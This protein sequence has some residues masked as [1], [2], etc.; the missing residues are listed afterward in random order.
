MVK[1]YCKNTECDNYHEKDC[2]CVADELRI[3]DNESGDFVCGTR[4]DLK[5][6]IDELLTGMDWELVTD[7]E[8]VDHINEKNNTWEF[9][10]EGTAKYKDREVQFTYAY[11]TGNQN[12]GG[13]HTLTN[14][15]KFTES[16][17]DEI[18]EWLDENYDYK[19][20]RG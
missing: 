13:G 10:V 19:N 7:Y 2:T 15:N 16:E 5:E 1:V 18:I 6:D 14:E 9:E 8:Q 17:Q 4:T 12:G 20:Y 3:F 11:S